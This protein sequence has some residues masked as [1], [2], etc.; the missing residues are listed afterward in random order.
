MINGVLL[1]AT[2]SS[3]TPAPALTVEAPLTNSFAKTVS[4][5]ADKADANQTIFNS[6]NAMATAWNIPLISKF[7]NQKSTPYKYLAS[8]A[9]QRGM[10]L[11]IFDGNAEGIIEMG[12]PL[13]LHIKPYGK[14]PEIYAPLTGV[15]NAEFVV[16]T[17]LGGKQRLTRKDLE[18][19]WHGRAIILWKNYDK[20]PAFLPNGDR[21]PAT[22][23][24]QKLLGSV[25]IAVEKSGVFDQKTV[26][27]LKSFQSLKGLEVT[28]RPNRMTLLY[29]YQGASGYFHPMLK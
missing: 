19:V 24:L 18:S 27:A 15:S 8:L 4:K 29:L 5:E 1:G 9:L 13:I 7:V 23:A 26:D 25:G 2:K 21:T 20:I 22:T 16:P 14:D 12:Y 17:G 11:I 6:F 10:E 28:G 3:H